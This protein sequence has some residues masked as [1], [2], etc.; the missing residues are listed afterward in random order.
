[1]DFLD[2]KKERRNFVTLL[3]GYCLVALAIAG[4]TLVL[5]YQAYG[6]SL[7]EQGQ[8][9]QSGLVFVSS[10]PTNSSIYLNNQLNAS[11]TNARLLVPAGPYNLKITRPGYRDWVRPIYVAGGD[12]QHFDYPFL[13]PTTLQ[14]SAVADLATS[15]SFVSQSPDQRW[16]LMDRPDVP[17][18]FTLYDLSNAKRPTESTITLPS[19]SYT[20][21][22]GVQ[23]WSV[24]EWANDSDHIVL[25]HTYTN[26]GSTDHEYILLDRQTPTSSINLTYNLNLSQDETLSLYNNQTSEVYV[27]DPDGQDLQ[28]IS[29]SNGDLVSKLEHVL[30]FKTYA[31]KEI[32]YIT[33]QPPDG[34][35]TPG[36]VSVILQDGQQSYTLRTLPAGAPSYVLNLAQYS[37]DW[38]I[39]V[40][41][42]NTSAV[43][44]YKDPQSQ[45]P[46]SPDQ[47]PA[48]WRRLNINDPTY[49]SFSNNTQ[50]LM[51]ESGQSFAVY[52][53]EN[54]N[55]YTYTMKQPLDQPQTHATWMDGDRMMY[56]SNGKLVVFDYDDRNVQ[57]LMPALPSYVP[58]FDPNYNYLFAL[59]PSAK[60]PSGSELTNTALLTPAD[61]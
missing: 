14:S 12:V 1:M 44:V 21:G 59:T 41:A 43:Y 49:I 5:L 3:L 60:D 20:P 22:D 26:S 45:S 6:Y 15:P 42:S 10:Q 8:V 54:V 47:Y 33:D 32:L 36:Q 24:E 61:Q 19:G 4:A 2:P 39:A 11:T 38:Y 51:A 34:K 48:P 57:T 37:G 35:V 55:G 58:M 17:G 28:R 50:F 29:V 52:D 30:A 16:I 25:D 23:S 9:T 13:F 40:G 7:N 27:Y 18:S 56:V 31:D 53:L 46:T